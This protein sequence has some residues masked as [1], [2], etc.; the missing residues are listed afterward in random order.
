MRI[1]LFL[2]PTFFA[3]GYFIIGLL[4]YNEKKY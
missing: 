1:W 2:G 4:Q 3:L